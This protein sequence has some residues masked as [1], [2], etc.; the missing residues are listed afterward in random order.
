VTTIEEI[1][2]VLPN[3]IIVLPLLS[4]QEDNTEEATIIVKEGT[5]QQA[6]IRLMSVKGSIKVLRGH[7]LK[8]KHAPAVGI[9]YDGEYMV[10][11]YSHRLDQETNMYTG[12]IK[13][14]RVSAV[15]SV[16]G[17]SLKYHANNIYSGEQEPDVDGGALEDSKAQ[18]IGRL[19]TV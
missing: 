7:T 6:H 10:E 18:S 17:K 2:T 13:L 4:G 1:V 3:G 16:G 12:R 15:Q 11:R 8:S 19:G 9:R 5:L 14:V